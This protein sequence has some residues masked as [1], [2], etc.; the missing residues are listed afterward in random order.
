MFV[1]VWYLDQTQRE[2]VEA[3][4]E[5]QSAAVL[6]H[7]GLGV[8]PPAAAEQVEGGE[9]RDERHAAGPSAEAVTETF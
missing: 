8:P 7:H 3:G 9:G 2:R 5:S 1:A 6:L 4:V